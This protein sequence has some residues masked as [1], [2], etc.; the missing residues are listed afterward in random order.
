[1]AIENTTI[2][3]LQTKQNDM[4]VWL[5]MLRYSDVVKISYVARRGIDEEKGAVQRFLNTSRIKSIK[6]FILSGSTFPNGI[7]LNWVSEHDTFSFSGGKLNLP[8]VERATQIIDGQHRVEGIKAALKEEPSKG[9]IEIP[10]LLFKNLST[11][12]CAKIFLSIN[13]EQRPVPKSLVYDLY[14]VAFKNRDYALE[15]AKDLA[16]ALNDDSDSPYHDW[17]K[18]PGSGKQ[19]GG[20][21]LSSVI[22]ALKKLVKKEDGDFEKFDISALD[23]Q[24]AVLKN[25]FTVIQQSYGTSWEKLTNPFIFASGFNAAIEVLSNKLLAKC[26]GEKDIREDLFRRLLKIDSNNL[27]QQSAVKGQSGETAKE[28]IRKRLESCIVESTA[29]RDYKR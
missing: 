22:T 13:T 28:T 29:N 26:Y 2:D 18:F 14:A 12:D 17:I 24:Y 25:Y 3:A 27:I 8:L 15:R 11:E 5:C 7:I 4:D 9:E 16:Q 1:M 21:Q 20:I 19:K 10:V 6:D 23:Y